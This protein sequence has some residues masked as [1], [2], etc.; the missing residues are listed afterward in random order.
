MVLTLL[1]NKKKYFLRSEC[2]QEEIKSKATFEAR[3][4]FLLA[5]YSLCAEISN[6][7]ET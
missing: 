2:W 5:K 3:S 6:L 7:V 4:Q 1:P